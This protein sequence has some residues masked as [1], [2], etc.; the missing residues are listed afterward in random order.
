MEKNEQTESIIQYSPYRPP[1]E[2]LGEGV[3][4]VEERHA[5]KGYP[6]SWRWVPSADLSLAP[7]APPEVQDPEVIKTESGAVIV[8]PGQELHLHRPKDIGTPSWQKE[9]D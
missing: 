9:N 2:K 4:V 1:T 6:L 8:P 7:E 3:W 5:E